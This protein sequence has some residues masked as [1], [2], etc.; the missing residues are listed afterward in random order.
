MTT[1]FIWAWVTC[2]SHPQYVLSGRVLAVLLTEV[3]F[4]YP[5]FPLS[6]KA[7]FYWHEAQ[8]YSMI[9]LKWI[10]AS[11]QHY[12][13]QTQAVTFWGKGCGSHTPLVHNH[14]VGY[15]HCSSISKFRL[16][17][18]CPLNC[19]FCVPSAE[20]S[21]GPAWFGYGLGLLTAGVACVAGLLT[22]LSCRMQSVLCSVSISFVGAN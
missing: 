21:L 7:C 1:S 16:Q 5:L 15:S 17:I 14:H 13:C 6:N 3:S 2:S 12:L 10:K 11:T 18:L 22:R 20:H 4:F 19:L 8:V 9:S